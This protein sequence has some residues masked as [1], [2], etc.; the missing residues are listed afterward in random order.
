MEE[1]SVLRCCPF[2]IRGQWLDL[3]K[4]KRVLL[5]ETASDR[6]LAATTASSDESNVAKS[7][8]KRGEIVAEVNADKRGQRD[9]S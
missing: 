4:A 7:I 9:E 5:R 3:V 8:W 2:N 1:R 6:R